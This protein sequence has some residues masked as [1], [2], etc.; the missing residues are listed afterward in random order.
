MTTEE[1]RRNINE[2][3]DKIRLDT[4]FK[5]GSDTRDQDEIK[6]QIKGD[7]PEECVTQLNE[8]LAL[9]T[10]TADTVRGIQPKGGKDD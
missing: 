7:D 6:I 3:A 4:K 2:S 1:T 10:E 5:R 8:T 9:L